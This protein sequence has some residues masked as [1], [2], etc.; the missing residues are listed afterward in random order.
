MSSRATREDRPIFSGGG[1]TPP[2]IS[3]LRVRF[4]IASDRAACST[5]KSK[6]S[7][8]PVAWAPGEVSRT[9]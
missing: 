1:K 7:P 9:R 5:V 2:A 8:A 3:R 6:R 4:D